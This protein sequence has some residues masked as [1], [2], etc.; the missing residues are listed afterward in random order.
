MNKGVKPVIV[1]VPEAEP[2][3]TNFAEQIDSIISQ[4]CVKLMQQTTVSAQDGKQIMQVLFPRQERRR[5]SQ[6][7]GGAHGTLGVIYV[8]M[9]AYLMDH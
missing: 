2:A 8:I 1:S 6:Y 9:Q 3:W 5:G 4:V 7:I